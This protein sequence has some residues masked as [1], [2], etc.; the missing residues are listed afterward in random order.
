MN[1]SFA[2]LIVDMEPKYEMLTAR[3][4]KYRTDDSLKADI[5]VRIPDKVLADFATENTNLTVAECE[6][7]LAGSAF[8]HRLVDFGGIMLHSSAVAYKGGAYLFSANSGTGKSTHTGLWLKEY[9]EDAVIINDDKPA[10]RLVGDKIMCCGTPFSGKH[11]ISVN[12]LY[13]VKGI[14]FIVRGEKNSIKPIPP[15]LSL[16]KIMEQTVRS[17]GEARAD[18]FLSLLSEILTRLPVYELTCN[19]DPEAAHVSFE[20]M[21]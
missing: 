21:R 4:A 6:Y 2:G 3:A 8:Y 11:D 18:K 12:E 10:L 13:P 15:S 1:Y 5:T 17:F 14:A 9:G 7:L 16:P 20:G 19:M